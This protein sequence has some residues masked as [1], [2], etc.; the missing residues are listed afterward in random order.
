VTKIKCPGCPLELEEDDVQAQGLHMDQAHPEIVAQRKRDN[1]F[2]LG[3]DG[4][5]HDVWASD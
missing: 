1:G 5:W 2:V 3:P 4:K